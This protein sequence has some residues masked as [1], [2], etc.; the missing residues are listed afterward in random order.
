MMRTAPG[1]DNGIRHQ[2]QMPFD[3]IPA[4]WRNPHQRTYGGKIAFF[5]PTI[6][7]VFQKLRERFFSRSE[8]NAICMR[9]RFFR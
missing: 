5:G 8:E 1:D 4:N 6:P 7:K 9:C 2:V 3:Q